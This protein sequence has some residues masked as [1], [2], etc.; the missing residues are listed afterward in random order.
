M[1]PYFWL[2]FMPKRVSFGYKSDCTIRFSGKTQ[3]L[4]FFGEK[5]SR[6][7]DRS[8]LKSRYLVNHWAD[9]SDFFWK[10]VREKHFGPK[11]FFGGE[12]VPFLIFGSKNYFLGHIY[13]FLLSFLI[14]FGK[15]C[16]KNVSLKEKRFWPFR[17]F[18]G[19]KSGNFWTKHNFSAIF[20]DF[21]GLFLFKF[22]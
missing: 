16:K 8:I 7:S 18:L 12:N 6:Q 1:A 10:N 11:K 21:Y 14:K 19:H 15:N 17:S 9:L 2:Q 4:A 5:H 20:L 13:G 3:F 22:G